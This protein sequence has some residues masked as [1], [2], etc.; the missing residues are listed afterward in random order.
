MEFAEVV[1][2]AVVAL[3]GGALA[4]TIIALRRWLSRTKEMAAQNSHIRVPSEMEKTDIADAE[5]VKI[6]ISYS[7]GQMVH[8]VEV[9]DIDI[10]LKFIKDL[11][12]F[13][14]LAIE[15]IARP[16]KESGKN[17]EDDPSSGKNI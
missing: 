4:N 13:N 10:A 16:N 3:G 14:H 8:T 2:I 6:R 11:E 15:S 17:A 5:P 9:Y 7:K 1:A 12:D